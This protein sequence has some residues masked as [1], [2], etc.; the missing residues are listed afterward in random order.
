[1]HFPNAFK[2]T[3]IPAV[4]NGDI[5]LATTG[6]TQDLTAGEIG[7]YNAKTYGI[8]TAA[9]AANTPF[10]IAQ[11]S[12]HTSDKIGPFHGGYQES[13]K[14]KVINPKYVSRFFKVAAQEPK[15]QIQMLGWSGSATQT[16]PFEFECNKTY[17][18]RFDVK[19]SP[20]LRTMTRNLYKTVDAFTG[21][22]QDNCSTGC[23]GDPVDAATVMYQWA[24]R[25]NEDPIMKEFVRATP[26][27]RKVNRTLGSQS[28]GSGVTGATTI[29]LDAGTDV[30]VGQYIFGTGIAPLTKVTAINSATVTISNALT[31]NAAGTYAFGE[32]ITE[33]YEAVV[34]DGSN[35]AAVNGVVAGIIVETSYVDTKFG[36]AT[37][38][39]T[40]HYELE[41]LF[42]YIS[43]VD[44]TGDPCVGKPVA[45]SSTGEHVTELQAV[46]VAS[47]V[48]ETVLRDYIL[49]QRYMQ[50]GFPDGNNMDQLR[51]REVLGD[52]ALST[53]SRTAMYDKY[54]L[55]HNVPRFNNP[56]STF[57]NDQYLLEFSVPAGTDASAFTDL[58]QDLIDLGGNGVTLET[59]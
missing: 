31:A 37:F 34:Y 47:G 54:Y 24:T 33:D 30:A 8:L 53:V 4:S 35:E 12:Y 44:E 14:S 49:S 39:V 38:T 19:G 7:I 52:T 5:S 22:C 46:V 15:S 32:V 51:L 13:V 43:L 55:L 10:I 40:D 28:G 29:V 21:C 27:W 58:L 2:K 16:S 20:A 42:V 17:W 59:Y 3:F 1:M 25:L 56:S 41:P 26:V 57:D 9:P 11:G 50:E 18:A 48:G 23:T 45:N 36:N 6:G